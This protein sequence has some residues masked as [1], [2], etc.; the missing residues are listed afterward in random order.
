LVNLTLYEFKS[1]LE[2]ET[3]LTTRDISWI[4]SAPL[5]FRPVFCSQASFRINQQEWYLWDFPSS[6]GWWPYS[7][8]RWQQSSRLFLTVSMNGSPSPQDQTKQGMIG[9]LLTPTSHRGSARYG[10]VFSGFV[11]VSKMRKA[12]FRKEEN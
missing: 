1:I 4:Y 11:A 3:K 7:S 5:P 8:G 6:F 12:K 2:L 10:V 9:D